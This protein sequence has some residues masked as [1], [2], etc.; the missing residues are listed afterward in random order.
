MPRILIAEDNPETRELL[1]M[2]LRGEPLRADFVSTG[3]EAVAYHHHARR[4]SDPY[5]A[6]IL[7]VAMPF[8]TGLTAA[9]EIRA[10]GDAVKIIFLTALMPEQIKDGAG[11]VGAG[12]WHKPIEPQGFLQNVREL[13]ARS[14][15]A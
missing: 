7:D 12:V 3:S 14:V 15:G 1:K 2:L 10:A 8:K 11:E 9:R 5:D 6:L 13:L 4:E